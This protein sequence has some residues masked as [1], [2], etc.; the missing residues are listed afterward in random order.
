LLLSGESYQS[1]RLAKAIDYL[2][3]NRIESTYLASVRAHIWASLPEEFAPLLEREAAYLKEAHHN[4]RFTYAVGSPIWSNSLTQYG[5]LGL[6][7][8]RKRGGGVDADFW[9]SVSNH[10]LQ[11]QQ[12]DGGWRYNQTRHRGGGNSTGSMTA[13]GVVVLQIAQQE[14]ARDQRKADPR[15]SEAIRR[16]VE[17]LDHRYDPSENTGFKKGRQYRFYYLYGIER[18]ALASGLSQLNGRDWFVARGRVPLWAGKLSVPGVAWNNRPND[19]YFLTRYLSDQ[20]EAELNWQVVSIDGDPVEWLRSPVLYFSSSDA[21]K[22]TAAQRDNLKRYLDLGGMLLVNPE[23]KSRKLTKSI[24]QLAK[25]MYPDYAFEQVDAEHPFAGLIIDLTSGKKRQRVKVKLQTLSNGVRDLIVMPRD[26]WGYDFQAKTPGKGIGWSLMTNLY[27][28]VTDRG[29]LN[30]RL[31]APLPVPNPEQADTGT[32]T[33]ARLPHAGHW[34]AEPA[35]LEVAGIDVFNRSGKTLDVSVWT[36]AQLDAAVAGAETKPAAVASG[37]GKGEDEGKGDAEWPSLV[38]LADTAAAVLTEEQLA[39][40]GRY[41]EAGGTVLLETVGGFGTFA[42][43][44]GS[45]LAEAVGG[46]RRWLDV[47]D[48]I[49]TGSG[50]AGGID[51]GKIE[52]RGYTVLQGGAGDQPIL[53][54]IDVAGRPAIIL[55]PRDLSLGALGS[56]YYKINGYQPASAR[57][58]LGNILLWAAGPPEK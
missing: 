13:A 28:T 51:A 50:I 11:E 37:E 8:Y 58:L 15:F 36:W 19:L 44:A 18:I 12:S 17:W 34:D 49:I 55:S 26:D 30:N 56:R 40:L 41:A 1:P 9:Q 38:H 16:G 43:D 48:P 47:A 24:Q 42:E 10:I 57:A 52:Y 54:A 21:V 20:R 53:G 27:A 22:L 2:R 4:G 45:Q 39:S 3:K 33:V 23:S 46:R 7:E 35:A 14:L 29:K 32:I 25:E 31:V 6:W 5:T